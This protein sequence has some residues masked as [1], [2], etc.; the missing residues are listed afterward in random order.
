MPQDD[1]RLVIIDE[2]PHF[3]LVAPLKRRAT[4]K[5]ALAVYEA[6]RDKGLRLLGQIP[7]EEWGSLAICEKLAM[8][9]QE[10][11]PRDV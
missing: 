10:Q 9:R 7:S 6:Y 11:E 5:E 1:D 3:V 2:S 4:R 8:S